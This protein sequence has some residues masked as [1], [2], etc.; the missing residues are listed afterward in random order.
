VRSAARDQGPYFE[1]PGGQDG[2]LGHWPGA[3]ARSWP[4]TRRD[5][6]SPVEIPELPSEDAIDRLVSLSAPY[7]R[8]TQPKFYSMES[9]RPWSAH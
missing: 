6:R 1:D 5:P 2:D 9:M 7:R 3:Q 4:I 8:I